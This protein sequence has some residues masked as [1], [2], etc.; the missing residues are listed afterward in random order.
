M[1]GFGDR[2]REV[3]ETQ[4]PEAQV[5][6]KQVTVT[7]VWAERRRRTVARLEC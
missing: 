1:R 2:K 3:P 6:G 7:R 5:P 4:L